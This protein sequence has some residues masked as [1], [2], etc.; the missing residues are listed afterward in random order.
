VAAT[1]EHCCYTKGQLGRSSERKYF[2]K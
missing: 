1:T 2:S